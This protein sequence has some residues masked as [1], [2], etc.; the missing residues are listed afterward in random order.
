LG[1]AEL[2]SSDKPIVKTDKVLAKKA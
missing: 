2:I 1:E